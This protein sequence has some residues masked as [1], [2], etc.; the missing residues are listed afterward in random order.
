MIRSVVILLLCLMPSTKRAT[1]AQCALEEDDEVPIGSVALP[2]SI[3][4]LTRGVDSEVSCFL[5]SRGVC[6]LLVMSA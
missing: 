2:I 4:N 3:D 1:A 5:D 6:L